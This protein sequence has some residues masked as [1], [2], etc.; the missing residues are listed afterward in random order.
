M[1]FSRGVE[2]DFDVKS[3]AINDRS[4]NNDA[5]NNTKDGLVGVCGLCEARREKINTK[6]AHGAGP[7]VET[8]RTF[9]SCLLLAFPFAPENDDDVQ[10]RL[11]TLWIFFCC[12]VVLAFFAP[13]G[14]ES[15]SLI[16]TW[17]L[18]ICVFFI[19]CAAP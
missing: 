19:L 14:F 15:C 18:K 16:E 6:R 11:I 8:R 12:S 13:F 17:D 2:R 4:D 1:I 7:D 9:F 10:I 3:R 5:L